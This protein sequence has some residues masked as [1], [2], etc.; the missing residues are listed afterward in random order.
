MNQHTSFF[1]G[2]RKGF[3]NFSYDIS[4]I[5]NLILLL[6]V[7]LLGVGITS[8]FS[9]IC[10]KHFLNIDSFKKKTTYWTKINLKKEPIDKYY[11]QF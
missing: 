6:L 9:K 8:I 7:Y 11:K 2:F 4:N 3:T 5:I 1:K 10:K